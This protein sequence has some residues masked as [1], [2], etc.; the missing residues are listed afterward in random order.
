MHKGGHRRSTS[1]GEGAGTY[2]PRLLEDV[3]Q[4]T[5]YAWDQ[6]AIDDVAA[7]ERAER[8]RQRRLAREGR[9][10][11]RQAELREALTTILLLLIG[12]YVLGIMLIELAFILVPLVFS[13]FLVYIFAPFIRALTVRRGQ[14]TGLPRWVAVLACLLVIFVFMGILMLII[15]FAIK[16]IIADAHQ[17]VESFNAIF[18]DVILFAERFGYTREQLYAMLPHINVG[19]LAIKVLQTLFDLFPQIILVLLIVVYMLLGL[20]IDVENKRSKLEETIDVQIRSYIMVPIAGLANDPSLD[21]WHRLLM[22]L[23]TAADPRHRIFDCGHRHDGD[24]VPLW[25]PL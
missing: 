19:E 14:E 3:G 25:H 11:E 13:R 2:R 18:T 10:V 6:A 1:G 24:S 23:T 7:E 8:R 15:G 5:F 12:F 20:E 16:G 4:A 17:Y 22:T 21:R 9:A